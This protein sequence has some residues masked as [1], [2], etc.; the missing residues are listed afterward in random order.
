M[1]AVIRPGSRSLPPVVARVRNGAPLDEV[2]LRLGTEPAVAVVAT[3]S[4][5]A[6]V[7]FVFSSVAVT[8]FARA[9]LG[10]DPI[11]T[12][13]LDGLRVER[14]IGAVHVGDRAVVLF[15]SGADVSGIAFVQGGFTLPARL[16][17]AVCGLED[18]PFGQDDAIAM[19]GACASG[20]TGSRLALVELCGGD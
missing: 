18:Q 19:F 13:D 6:P 4:A 7:V 14:G 9:G 11:A 15:G 1:T 17:D 8:A 10:F 16:A 5:T 2:P 3:D 20:V 12:A